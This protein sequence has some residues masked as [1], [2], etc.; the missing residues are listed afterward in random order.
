M[1]EDTSNLAVLE[2]LSKH[3]TQAA[4][5]VREAKARAGAKKAE[6]EAETIGAVEVQA[7]GL[8]GI[9]N[10]ADTSVRCLIDPGA[11][12]NCLSWATFI[13]LPNHY[14]VQWMPAEDLAD[15]YILT[16]EFLAGSPCKV[17]GVVELPVMSPLGNVEQEFY[18]IE[19]ARLDLLGNPWMRAVQAAVCFKHD[20]VRND[21]ASM[22]LSTRSNYPN[23]D[24][25]QTQAHITEIKNIKD[26][27][28]TFDPSLNEEQRED[29]L[30][31]LNKHSEVWAK[32]KVACS[33][34]HL[35]R[36]DTGAAP[37]VVSPH[38]HY[39]TKTIQEL[40]RLT[41]EL[42]EA[43]A[44]RRS[45]S[46]W[47]SQPV[48]VTKK[49][50]TSRLC[51]DFRNL[52]AV[53]ISDPFQAPPA[54]SVIAALGHAKVFIVMDL[55]NSFNQIKLHP[56]D[57]H[58]T[59]FWSPLG[60]MEWTCVAF[61]LLNGTSAMARFLYINLLGINGVAVY[62]DDIVIYAD[63]VAEALKCLDQV[64]ARLKEIG[65]CVNVNKCRFGVKSMVFLGYH[66]DSGKVTP[67]QES[68][69][70]I[71]NIK[72]PSDV[73]QVRRLLGMVGYF[74]HFIKDFALVAAPLYELLQKSE[75]FTMTETR[76][77]AIN[78]LKAKLLECPTL[79]N[80][81]PDWEY[82]LD[83]DASTTAIGAVLMQ[84]DPEGHLYPLRFGS[85]RLT[86]TERNWP[87]YELEGFAIVYF[88]LSYRP[89]LIGRHFT[90]HSD[91]KPLQWLWKIDKPRLARWSMAIQQFDFTIIYNPG[92][93]QEHADIFTRDVDYTIA[94][95]F[96]DKH[97][98]FL[99][100]I[101][102]KERIQ[103]IERESLGTDPVE[104]IPVKTR[105][106]VSTE[107]HNLTYHEVAFP[108]PHDFITRPP[109]YLNVPRIASRR[110]ITMSTSDLVHSLSR[111]HCE[112]KYYSAFIIPE[113]ERTKELRR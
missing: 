52:N 10:I 63:S 24:V 56:D 65:A 59:A 3:F 5:R 79:Y 112:A 99:G 104:H 44:L 107:N 40:T 39:S 103:R 83:T 33:K 73:T 2:S 19:G 100:P 109:S 61:G 30:A 27:E 37:P 26:L 12:R 80:P 64:L 22:S 70:A 41:R 1:K 68:I 11:D 53:T 101:N 20:E 88:I 85:R 51:V 97:L 46:S 17:K 72:V 113:L 98:P 90:I 15:E 21:I 36:I 8:Y 106:Q 25:L 49:D 87:I 62:V 34:G 57:A 82:V 108:S 43:G 89:Y 9:F 67:P 60:Q 35:Y 92:T 48:L 13:G 45:T 69:N 58:K 78:Q 95:E 6:A 94:D 18:I 96:V 81:H 76:I 14:K 71:Q 91:H 55:K 28:A 66:I 105:A 50:G 111:T 77:E 4:E 38:R 86:P 54:A 42:L 84:Q 31:V 32:T 23:H 93:T 102:V 75:P 29:I 7:G 16:L 47:L 74:R 110:K